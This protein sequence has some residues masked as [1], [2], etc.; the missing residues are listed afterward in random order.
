MLA[1]A[2]ARAEDPG[3]RGILDEIARYD[4]QLVDL[5]K[6]DLATTQQEDA[7]RADL[8]AHQ[9]DEETATAEV[10]RR[11]TAVDA[12]LRAA[13]RL[14]RRGF[15]RLLFDA[16]SPDELRRRVHYLLD[17]V[18]SQDAALTSFGAAVDARTKAANAAD[19]E[20]KALAALSADRAKQRDQLKEERAHRVALLRSVQASPVLSG[21]YGAESQR[22]H[23]DFEASVAGLGDGTATPVI[24]IDHSGEAPPATPSPAS[25]SD[26]FRAARGS[27]P[28]PL[29]GRI[30]V[31][32][33]PYTDPATQ[34]TLQNLGLDIAA[35]PGTPF[36]AVFSGN[37]ARSGYV[38]GYGQVVMVTHGAYAT[39]YAHANGLRVSQGQDVHA[40]DVLGLVGSTG[41]L[42]ES[43]ARL[44]FE[45]RYNG[46]P[47]DPTPWLQPGG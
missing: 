10:T 37:V 11:R 31:G 46:T 41:L 19:A 39:L 25:G 22:A 17:T 32:W 40:G 28:W 3:T 12:G 21:Q 7:V 13:Y 20:L 8:A 36:R 45:V 14:Q 30:V 2:T 15:A 23:A 24:T 44:H 4:A 35:A 29:H 47:Q 6:A 27:L 42:D 26:A 1:G 16:Q 5:D 38:R 34:Q 33:G 9:S 18:R 43:E